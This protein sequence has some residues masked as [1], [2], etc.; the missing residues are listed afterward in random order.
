MKID[1]EKYRNNLP[2]FMELVA[3]EQWGK[4]QPWQKEMLAMLQHAPERVIVMP[5]R[6]G[7]YIFIEPNEAKRR[8]NVLLT[9]KK[10]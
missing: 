6:K 3:G 10:T 2:A 1:I 9:R 8:L 7:H 5:G 4:L